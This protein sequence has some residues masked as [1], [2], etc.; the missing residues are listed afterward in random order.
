MA[1]G[2]ETAGTDN[3]GAGSGAMYTPCALSD[4]LDCPWVEDVE[5]ITEERTLLL[6][7]TGVAIIEASCVYWPA[8]LVGEF[9]VCFA[10]GCRDFTGAEIAAEKMVSFFPGSGDAA[11]GTLAERESTVA[12]LLLAKT[13]ANRVAFRMS[14][15]RRRFF[16]IS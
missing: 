8:S 7:E 12:V 2:D 4:E 1:T 14:E 6:P 11:A 13:S 3:A 9:A 16:F 5:T 10:L 15:P